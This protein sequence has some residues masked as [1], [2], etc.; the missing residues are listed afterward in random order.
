M[1]QKAQEADPR[2][3]APR[4]AEASDVRLPSGRQLTV[5]HD[6]GT[7]VVQV[8]E[9]GGRAVVTVRLTEAGPEVTVEGANVTLRA[10]DTLTLEARRVRVEAREEASLHSGGA[11]SLSGAAGVDVRSVADV[12]VRGRIIHLN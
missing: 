8:F 3:R 11:L 10:A 9:A 7:E 2:Q 4:V 6:G 1:A 12:R 5:R